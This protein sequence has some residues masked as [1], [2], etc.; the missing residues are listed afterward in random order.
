MGSIT[1]ACV[2]LLRSTR[3]VNPSTYDEDSYGPKAARGVAKLGFSWEAM[4]VRI[5]RD[6]EGLAWG[7]ENLVV[8]PLC[9]GDAVMVQEWITFDIE[10]RM[11]FI[12]PQLCSKDGK[13]RT[14]K[15]AKILYTTFER[16]DGENKLRDFR[17]LQR[18][19]DSGD[20]HVL[21]SK[22][23]LSPLCV[24]SEHVVERE[25]RGDEA[26][27]AAAE[28]QVCRTTGSKSALKDWCQAI[29]L[30][31]KLLLWLRTECAE[32]PTVIRFDFMVRRSGPAQA[33]VRSLNTCTTG[34]CMI[35]FDVTGLDW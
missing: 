35:Q 22:A 18:Y 17:R 19:A 29:H 14:V 28:Q 21:Y 31:N 34:L 12:E 2:Q 30:G 27:L 15:P 9:V 20:S 3:S 23:L 13:L 24:Y 33:E 16:V 7:L 11:F 6:F 1:M 32:P 10:L 4:D 26:A 5:F 8:Q 25:F